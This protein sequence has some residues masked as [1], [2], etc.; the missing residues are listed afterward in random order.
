LED[1]LPQNSSGD[2]AAGALATELLMPGAQAPEV[3]AGGEAELGIAQGSEIVPV[4]DACFAK[5]ISAA[6]FRILPKLM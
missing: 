3:V 5:H 4:A 1:E 2:A 6:P